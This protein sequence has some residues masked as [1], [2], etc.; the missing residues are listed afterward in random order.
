M[1][2]LL[3]GKNNLDSIVSI[4]PENGFLN[5][6]QEK[7]NKVIKSRIDN[8]FWILCNENIGGYLE[9]NLHY[10]YYKTFDTKNAYWSF[11]KYNKDKD[12]YTISDFK[13]NSMVKTGITYYKGLKPHDI[14]I[15]SFDLETTTLKLVPESQIL[16]ISTT[17]RKNNIIERKLFA[18]NDYESTQEFLESFAEYVREKDP[19]ILCGHNIYGFDLKYLNFIAK[20][21]DIDLKLGRDKS[22]LRV[23]NYESKYRIDQTRELHYNKAFIYGREIVDTLFLAYKYDIAVK[24]YE[25]YGLKSIIQTEGLVDPNRTFYDAAKI[26]DNYKNPMEWQKIKEYCKDDSDDALKLYDLMAP[27]LFYTT[28]YIPKSFSNIVN[29]ATGSQINSIL[30]RGYLQ[31]KHSVP[32]ASEIKPFKGAISFGI[33]GIYKNMVKI[34]FSGLYPSI[35][36][37]FKVQ[38]LEK[39]P[40]GYFQQIVQ[41][42]TEHRLKHKK[43]YKETNLKY[44]DDMQ[45]AGKIFVNSMYGFLSTSGLNFN[46]PPG[47]E[48][49]PSKGREFLKQSIIWATGKDY[50]YWFEK[51]K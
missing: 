30:V 6:F 43:L 41:Y 10:K 4:E 14:S 21:E 36:R 32:K 49:I 19:S 12:L 33:P 27:P 50:D 28:P 51:I 45:S 47:A 15:M 16:L 3:T 34:D 25:S 11:K 17:Y 24:K 46:D 5:V 8:K 18:Y 35:I 44:H 1:N 13:E 48:F 22:N 9:G 42:F 29:S 38:N 2:E 7:D 26:R 23:E 20:R 39:D 40:K 31:N 37:Q